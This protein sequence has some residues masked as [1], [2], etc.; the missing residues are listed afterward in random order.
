MRE[1]RVNVRDA[2]DGPTIQAEAL[3]AAVCATKT[4]KERPA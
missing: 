3:Q 2:Q 1:V 4:F